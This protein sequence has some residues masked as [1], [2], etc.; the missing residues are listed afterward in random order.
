IPILNASFSLFAGV[1]ARWYYMPILIMTS[2]CAVVMDE[3]LC[4]NKSD[5]DNEIYRK[6]IVKASVI[7]IAALIG[8]CAFLFFVKWDDNTER[9]IYHPKIFAVFAGISLIGSVLTLLI[10]LYKK[11]MK[12]LFFGGFVCIFALVTTFGLVYGYRNYA[13]YSGNEIKDRLEAYGNVSIEDCYRIDTDDNYLD[14][15]QGVSGRGT[16]CSTVSGSIFEFYD[17]LGLKR[18]VKSPEAPEGLKY[19]ISAAYS[20]EDEPISEKEY[21]QMYE[22]GDFVCYEYF[23]PDVPKIGFTYDTYIT[24]SEIRELDTEK[25]VKC[26]LAALVVPDDFDGTEGMNHFD[27]AYV[28]NL[29][30]YQVL[31][32]AHMN[33]MSEEFTKDSD[34]FR[35]VITSASEKYAYFSIPDDKGWTAFVNGEE[36]EIVDSAGMMAVRIESGRNEI[37]FRYETVGLKEGVM[38]T[39]TAVIISAV[40][41]IAFYLIKMIKRKRSDSR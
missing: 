7:Q 30:D 27:A 35:S 16:F 1:Y 9:L 40:Y 4:R 22:S 21:T 3:F 19:L 36:T 37:E 26:M 31:A 32:K 6:N 5:T 2:A 29:P 25:R 34:G 23:D 12:F 24:E 10:L 28:D 17:L 14:L 11:R 38:V 18:T 41:L 13:A 33:E 20:M 8:F 39:A 15:G